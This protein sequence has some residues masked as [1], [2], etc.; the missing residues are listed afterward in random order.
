MISDRNRLESLCGQL[1]ILVVAARAAPG[2][3]MPSLAEVL[4]QLTLTGAGEAP[5]EEARQAVAEW[6]WKWDK[7]LRAG[8][9]APD[10]QRDDGPHPYSHC[11]I[12]GEKCQGA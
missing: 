4:W 10:P 6:A 7:D 1:A 3:A 5:W 12:E 8:S 11:S 2:E 9:S